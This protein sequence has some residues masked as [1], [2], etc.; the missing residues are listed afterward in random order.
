MEMSL[1]T[2]PPFEA[3]GAFASAVASVTTV[4]WNGSV[5]SEKKSHQNDMD[6]DI[7]EF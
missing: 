7:A 1:Y 4:T 3:V 6:P 5:Q 2:V